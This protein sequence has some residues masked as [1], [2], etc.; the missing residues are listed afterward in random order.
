MRYA[1]RDEEDHYVII[2]AAARLK[3]IS[4]GPTQPSFLPPW[5]SSECPAT[6]FLAQMAL[7][8]V[9]F[10]STYLD[11]AVSDGAACSISNGVCGLDDG[12][13]VG[14]FDSVASGVNC[15]VAVAGMNAEECS[16]ASGTAGGDTPGDGVV[17]T[18]GG[19]QLLLCAAD[20]VEAGPPGYAVV[21]LPRSLA[22][23][24]SCAVEQREPVRE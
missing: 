1:L 6:I 3:R 24:A 7:V 22:D 4:R 8:P 12:V 9:S 17:R 23:V 13:V 5:Q 14:G 19:A 21:H 15:S 16:A 11:V 20:E 10:A 18:L 2:S